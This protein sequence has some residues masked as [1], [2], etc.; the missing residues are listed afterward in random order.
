M[1]ADVSFG[2]KA[3]GSVG[4]TAGVINNLGE[5]ASPP[6]VLT[7]DRIATL[8]QGIEVHDI[9][10]EE[11]FWHYRELP[12]IVMNRA[13]MKT[14]AHVLR[15]RKIGFLYQRYTLHGYTAVALARA[16]RVPLVTHKRL[17]GLGRASLGA[18]A[19][20]RDAG[21][22][23]R[24]AQS[25]R[26]R[27]SV[28]VVS[29]PLA[30]EVEALGVDPARVLINPNGV[31]VDRYRPDL[32]ASA[33]RARL[34]VSEHTVVGFIGTFGPWH[35][36]EVLAEAAVLLFQSQPEWRKTVRVLFIGD[37]VGLAR[38]KTI[39]EEGGIAECCVFTGLVPQDEGAEHLAACDIL[40]SPHV[41]NADGSPFFGS[42]TK[43]FEY[44][45]MGKASSRRISI[46]SATCSRHG[47]DGLA[48]AAGDAARLPAQCRGS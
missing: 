32:D 7:T 3:G 41:P 29:T 19:D 8:A 31:D 9:V 13:I 34:R 2:V 14:A 37:G 4:H 22:T 38:V 36:A 24:T 28:S 39:V 43:L 6:I 30:R 15:E 20:A 17:G 35:G 26:G 46:R 11:A 40:A 23:D 10:P 42:P 21:D 45:A 47:R 48:G 25:P 16:H 33:S 44:M 12:A 5:S 27:S 1:R 18:A